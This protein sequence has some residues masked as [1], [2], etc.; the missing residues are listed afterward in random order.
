MDHFDYFVEDYFEP[1]IQSAIYAAG[2]HSFGSI[3]LHTRE[4]LRKQGLTEKELD[5]VEEMFYPHWQ[6]KDS[7]FIPLE[8][9]RA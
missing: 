2:I 1:N 9:R 7:K 6:L 8:P 3:A 5:W 4:D